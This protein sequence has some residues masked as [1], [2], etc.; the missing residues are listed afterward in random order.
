MSETET[1]RKQLKAVKSLLAILADEMKR[2]D[3]MLKR[4]VIATR[5]RVD[6]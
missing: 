2:L 1:I 4:I 6:E 5:D 3:V